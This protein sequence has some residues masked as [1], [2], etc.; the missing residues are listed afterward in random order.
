[1]LLI[2]RACVVFFAAAVMGLTGC[3]LSPQQLTPKVEVTESM[4]ATG[5]GQPVA[6]KVI[7]RR[8]SP[9]LGTR[10]GV[11]KDSST[12]TVATDYVVP[13]LEQEANTMLAK[14]GYV[15]SRGGGAQLTI[16]LAD[17]TYNAVSMREAKVSA[18]LRTHLVNGGQSYNGRY[19]ASMEQSFAKI[20]SLQANTDMVG[21]V[22]SDA[23]TR[24][25]RDP[26]LPRA[27]SR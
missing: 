12:I 10:G 9:Q 8:P 5:H 19:S 17:L 27:L 2:K 16:I 15:P 25:F 20:P 22:L 6:I 23:L 21:Q 18:L 13:K 3:A 1:M 4:V 11:Y 24:L 14:L 26:D 7:D